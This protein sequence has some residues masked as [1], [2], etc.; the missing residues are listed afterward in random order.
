MQCLIESTGSL[1]NQTQKRKKKKERK[2]QAAENRARVRS[3][4]VRS[5]AGCCWLWDSIPPRPPLSP[6]L[7]AHL[8]AKFKGWAPIS[9]QPSAR[10]SCPRCQG[11]GEA[12]IGGSPSNGKR[13]FFADSSPAS[14]VQTQLP[15]THSKD[16]GG[17]A[18]SLGRYST[19][20]LLQKVL[21]G[22]KGSLA[23]GCC[24]P[25]TRA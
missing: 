11:E 25:G 20:S 4:E 8:P 1:E 15:L 7:S 21:W 2:A 10:C 6:W 19:R 5:Q 9:N 16:P 24:S 12:E 23:H 13:T 17:W 18:N 22:H 3:Q 14:S